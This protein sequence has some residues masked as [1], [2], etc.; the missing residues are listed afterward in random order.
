MQMST[1]IEKKKNASMKNLVYKYLKLE[2]RDLYI[3]LVNTF[4]FYKNY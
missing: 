1:V 3:I 4:F 2:P